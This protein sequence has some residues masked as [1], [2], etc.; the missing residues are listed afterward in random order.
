[1]LLCSESPVA[2]ERGNCISLPKDLC[3]YCYYLQQD[4][5]NNLHWLKPEWQITANKSTRVHPLANV[6]QSDLPSPAAFISS[7][8]SRVVM[9]PITIWNAK[10]ESCRWPDLTIS[11]ALC[12]AVD[13]FTMIT[14][15]WK[16]LGW[17]VWQGLLKS[18][19]FGSFQVLNFSSE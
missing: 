5:S 7:D 17:L 14:L 19:L 15:S 2:M 3:H 9:D 4:F 10:S 18:R 13:L 12:F 11:P 8:Q 6:W 1:M 16:D